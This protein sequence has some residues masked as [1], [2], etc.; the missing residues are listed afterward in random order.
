MLERFS[1][2]ERS[3]LQAEVV[4]RKDAPG[5]WGVEAID[6]EDDGAIS[7]AIFSGPDAKERALEYARSKY[8]EVNSLAA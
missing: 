4:P 2:M 3:N 8:R 7:V 1:K 5:S 6:Y